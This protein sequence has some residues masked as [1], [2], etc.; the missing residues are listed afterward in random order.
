MANRQHQQRQQT[1][2]GATTGSGALQSRRPA[3]A[4]VRRPQY[5]GWH[6][7]VGE[8]AGDRTLVAVAENFESMDARAVAQDVLRAV[9]SGATWHEPYVWGCMWGVCVG[10]GVGGGWW[11]WMGVRR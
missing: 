2:G 8:R 3:S 5:S 7:D 6:G 10:A 1:G 9:S 4:H 11:W